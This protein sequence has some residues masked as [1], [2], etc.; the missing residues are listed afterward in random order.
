MCNNLEKKILITQNLMLQFP[1]E[2]GFDKEFMG[3]FQLRGKEHR[4]K[5]F[6]INRVA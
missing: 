3:E 5:V 2:N 6:G 1:G 4:E